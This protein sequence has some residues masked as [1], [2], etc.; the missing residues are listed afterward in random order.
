MDENRKISHSSYEMISKQSETADSKHV[1][2]DTDR[3]PTAVE[4]VLIIAAVGNCYLISPTS[5]W[6]EHNVKLKLFL[7]FS[8]KLWFQY[9]ACVLCIIPIHV[10][11]SSCPQTEYVRDNIHTFR[12][13]EKLTWIYLFVKLT[14][15]MALVQMKHN[16][17][18][19][20]EW[21]FLRKCRSFWDGQCLDAGGTWTT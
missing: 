11:Q 9:L 8:A 14:F 12:S 16:L 10:G 13:T 6:K 18:W 2:Y 7:S 21:I 4:K 17:F 20:H 5:C 19:T 3:A 15:Q 1:Y